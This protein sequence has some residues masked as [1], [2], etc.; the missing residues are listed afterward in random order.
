[1]NNVSSTKL[2]FQ[3]LT[4]S[5]LDNSSKLDKC[6]SYIS[7]GSITRDSLAK[8]IISS[9]VSLAQNYAISN[10]VFGENSAKIVELGR[11]TFFDNTRAQAENGLGPLV[12]LILQSKGMSESACNIATTLAQYLGPMLTQDHCAERILAALTK[13]DG[14]ENVIKLALRNTLSGVCGQKVEKWISNTFMSVLKRAILDRPEYR[15]STWAQHIVAW[16]LYQTLNPDSRVAPPGMLLQTVDF[17]VNQTPGMVS[18]VYQQLDNIQQ[19]LQIPYAEQM[20]STAFEKSSVSDL[21]VPEDI[22]CKDFARVVVMG[23]TTNQNAIVNQNIDL[24]PQGIRQALHQEAEK[25][26]ALLTRLPGQEIKVEQTWSGGIN[27]VSVEQSGS[28]PAP[29]ELQ[30][31]INTQLQAPA[32]HPETSGTVVADGEFI[33]SLKKGIDLKIDNS[34]LSYGQRLFDMGN[35][36]ITL[37]TRSWGEGT[38]LSPLKQQQLEQLSLMVENNPMSML[39]LSRYL[40]PD[41]VAS[42]FQQIIFSQFAHKEPNLIHVDNVWMKVGKPEVSFEVK[43]DQGVDIAV[44]LKWPVT[45]FGDDISNLSPSSYKQSYLSSRVDINMLFN[46]HGLEKEQITIAD[47]HLLLKDRLVF[48]SLREDDVG[49][50]GEWG[51]LAAAT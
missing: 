30:S 17:V 16:K 33:E 20:A 29:A 5:C 37:Y 6:V 45:E 4:Y 9:T 51:T 13:F 2:F 8:N 24:L 11:S 48:T 21:A 23:H 15:E 12:E 46:S 44:N 26:R 35:Q 3:F 25:V 14:G 1:M 31:F 42:R 27:A 10:Q 39:A 38:G 50:S 32:H 18:T 40:I 43:K 34:H 22:S 28:F 41:S 36:F 7:R 49:H 47:T 19:Y